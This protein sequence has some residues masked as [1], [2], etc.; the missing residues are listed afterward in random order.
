MKRVLIVDDS[1]ELGRWLQTALTTMDTTIQATVFPSGEEALLDS[2]RRPVDVLVTDIRLAGISGLEL[3]R[4]IRRRYPGIRVIVITGMQDM[5]L[6]K[7]ANELGI[8]GFFRKPMDIPSFLQAVNACLKVEGSPAAPIANP[9]SQP[10]PA[11]APAR[12]ELPTTPA[13]VRDRPETHPAG[14]NSSLAVLL[15]GL[16]KDMGALAVLLLDENG[17]VAAKSGSFP[18]SSFENNWPAAL[19]ETVRASLKISDLLGSSQP[20]NL[21]AMQ[22]MAFD[23]VLS[24]VGD[25]A[26]VL[27]LRTGRPTLRM[28]LAFEEI[29]N[30]QKNLLALIAAQ[31]V[32]TPLPAHEARPPAGPAEP[33]QEKPTPPAPKTGPLAP[34]PASKIA[35]PPVPPHPEEPPSAEFAALFGKPGDLN[36]QD[37]EDFWAAA[38]SAHPSEAPL[39]PGSDAITYEQARKMGLAPGLDEEET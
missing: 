28:G 12:T 21:I 3:V 19:M 10:A 15:E 23:L 13:P 1:L 38:A 16:R 27:A 5:S 26:L 35:E 30:I 9:Q 7:Q 37:V 11:P 2:S 32:V 8:D 39:T 33:V 25:Y 24:P 4:K 31:A 36:T 29:L 18:D 6:E 14:A 20:R 34:P 17:Q 22:G